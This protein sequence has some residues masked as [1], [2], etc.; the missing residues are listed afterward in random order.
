MPTILLDTVAIVVVGSVWLVVAFAFR[1][2]LLARGG[3]TVEMCLRLRLGKRGRGWVLGTGRYV[4]DDLQ[5]FRVFSLAPHPRRTLSRRGLRVGQ[6]R[7]P[8]GQERLALQSGMVILECEATDG[9]VQ[10]AIGQ[11][12]LNGF[13]SWLE[14]AASGPVVGD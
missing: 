6:R 10:I 13:L 12:A 2:W 4:G 3:G 5:W 8:S 14:A 1:R 7:T 11:V 9:P